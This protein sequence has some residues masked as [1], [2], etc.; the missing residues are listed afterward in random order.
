[1]SKE[2]EARIREEFG[3]DVT[4]ADIRQAKIIAGVKIGARLPVLFGT[5]YTIDKAYKKL[6]ENDT[7]DDS[8]DIS[9]T[10]NTEMEIS[11]IAEANNADA[12]MEVTISENSGARDYSQVG[13]RV[14]LQLGKFG[15]AT[16]ITHGAGKEIDKTVD[17]AFWYAEEIKNDLHEM[18]QKRKAVL[19]AQKLAAEATLECQE[20]TDEFTEGKTKKSKKK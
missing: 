3:A 15:I 10:T 9:E 6:F 4:K 12:D 19:E 2:L 7:N 8:T 20:K 5:T 16:A 17:A 13:Q 11:N 18:K 14:A 1:M